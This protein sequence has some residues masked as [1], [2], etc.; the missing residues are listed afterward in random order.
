M[1]MPTIWSRSATVLGTAAVMVCLAVGGAMA[2]NSQIQE[3]MNRVSR[4]QN[5]LSTLQRQVY[6]NAP[7]S[8]AAGTAPA[9]SPGSP[10][11][12]A[13]H[14]SVRM[15]QLEDELRRLTGRYEE[16]NHVIGQMRARLDKLV[17]DVDYR[18]AV[19]EQGGTPAAGR[20][21]TVPPPAPGDAQAAI[22]EP[23][24]GQ[25]VLGTIP[26]SMLAN[27]TPAP[28]GQALPQGTP[29]EQ[30]DRA[31]ALIVKEQNFEEAERVLL[32]FIKAYPKNALAAN[33]HYWL[34]RTY[35]VRENFKQAAFTFAE[36]FQKYPKSEK[37]PAN[38]LNLGMSL[39]QLK[40]K[41]EACTAYSR[42]LKRFPQAAGN[43]KRRTERERGKLK[44]R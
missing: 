20:S 8:R 12:V 34:G 10:R 35:F 24:P 28:A 30:Y 13:A 6:R 25:R 42:L 2:Q 26:Q 7:G 43:V 41:K 33:A 27:R 37:A 17:T 40:Q 19:I 14:L 3:L 15:T 1:K 44:C 11:R 5:E 31:H 9:P 4:L 22:P 21:L 39:A 18:L 32:A 29:K 16:F 36:G 38:L 23:S